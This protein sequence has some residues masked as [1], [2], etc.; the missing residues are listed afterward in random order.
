MIMAPIL[1]NL[2]SGA[3]TFSADQAQLVQGMEGLK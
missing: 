1:K 2:L 3:S